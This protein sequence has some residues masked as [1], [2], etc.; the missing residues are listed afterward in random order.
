M[1]HLKNIDLIHQMSIQLYQYGK[2]LSEIVNE[3]ESVQ[4]RNQKKYTRLSI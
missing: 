2:N 1:F 4:E 3:I